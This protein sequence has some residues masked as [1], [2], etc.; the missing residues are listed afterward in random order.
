MPPIMGAAMRFITSA[1]APERFLNR[2]GRAT[3]SC[4]DEL[5]NIGLAGSALPLR[6]GNP[7]NP[8]PSSL[9][10]MRYGRSH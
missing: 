3:L 9:L 5:A 4:L 6:P 10:S 2:F 1:P 8:K 7:S